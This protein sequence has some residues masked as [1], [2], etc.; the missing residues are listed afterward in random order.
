MQHHTTRDDATCVLCQAKSEQIIWQDQQIRV[1]RV[2]GEQATDFPLYYRVIWRTH[3]T[4]FSQLSPAQRKHCMSV[5]ASVESALIKQCAPTKVNL[6]SLGN[7]V[8]HLHWH[9]IARFEWARSG[10]SRCVLR[11]WSS[12]KSYRRSSMSWTTW[13][14]AYSQPLWARGLN[15]ALR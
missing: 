11:T 6:A 9:V 12:Y 13:C 1:I 15:P 14:S 8:A 7:L 2:T 4:E 3:V 5:V 10:R